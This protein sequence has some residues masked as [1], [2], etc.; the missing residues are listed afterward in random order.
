MRIF[1]VSTVL[2]G[3]LSLPL[4]LATGEAAAATPVL[5]ISGHTLVVRT[6]ME[7]ELQG[8]LCRGQFSC[9]KV[10]YRS[11]GLG[12]RPK[13]E[14]VEILQ[15]D[16]QATAG[17]A[18][19]FAYSQGGEIAT[20]WLL[21]YG[22]STGRVAGQPDEVQ[23]VLAGSPDNGMGGLGPASGSTTAPATPTDTGYTIIE[24]SRE[25]DLESDFPT[26][27]FNSF[28]NANA[29][30]GYFR[31]HMDYTGVDLTDPNNLV[32]Q[33]GGTTYVLVPTENLPMLDP[34]LSLHLNGL[35]DALNAKLKPI[36]DSAYDR[37]GYVTLAE[38]MAAG[39]EL[40]NLLTD[41]PP[42]AA[43]AQNAVAGLSVA[44]STGSGE[45][46]SSAAAPVVSAE[47][48][49][50]GI[51]GRKVS[52]AVRTRQKSAAGALSLDTPAGEADR[53]EDDTAMRST[54]S[55]RHALQS[56]R[57]ADG[58]AAPD[59]TDGS[60]T[61]HASDRMR[62]QTQPRHSRTAASDRAAARST[63]RHAL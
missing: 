45:K 58:M 6:P 56:S 21:K 19:V 38:A 39:W 25:Y 42:A 54:R 35:H 20:S 13:V 30:S 16:L 63:G 8:R 7:Q 12:G 62:V 23:F 24:V 48:A 46:A 11:S 34:L 33:K 44:P 61:V 31:V 57:V 41:L 4:G 51:G 50:P 55:P 27:R 1:A 52:P 60:S 5:T 47:S 14:A 37:T 22:A 53:T 40:P 29:R 49:D 2:A 10:D 43:P 9:Q 26:K 28:A 3:A 32:L 17:P 36:V 18:I 59:K 15:N